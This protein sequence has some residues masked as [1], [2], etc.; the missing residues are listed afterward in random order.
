MEKLRYKEKQEN[1]NLRDNSYRR[2]Q[3]RKQ[4]NNKLS[5]KPN[6]RSPPGVPKSHSQLFSNKL[7]RKRRKL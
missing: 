6:P 3:R 7:S 5:K 1:G 4:R 2:L